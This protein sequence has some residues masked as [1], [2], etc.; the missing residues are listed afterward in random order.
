MEMLKVCC[1]SFS[2]AL[3]LLNEDGENILFYCIEF[4]KQKQL[5]LLVNQYKCSLVIVNKNG[6]DLLQYC[7]QFDRPT[8]KHII[9]KQLNQELN[10]E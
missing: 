1:D 10:D 4:D 5:K 7:D 3:T 2:S 9:Q 8:C 6:F